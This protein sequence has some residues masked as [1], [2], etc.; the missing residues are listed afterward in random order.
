[1][2]VHCEHGVG[3]SALLALCVLV[4][5]GEAPLAALERAKS[6]RPRVSPSPEQLAAFAA[7]V[8]RWAARSGAEVAVPTLDDLGRIAWRH[9]YGGQQGTGTE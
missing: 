1:V 3:R 8:R 9:L 5:R 6:A 7:W 4:A 2:L